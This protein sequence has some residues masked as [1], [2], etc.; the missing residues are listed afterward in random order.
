ASLGS[1]QETTQVLLQTN[2]QLKAEYQKLQADIGAL[3]NT[4][5]AVRAKNKEQR[6]AF[7]QRKADIESPS[8]IAAVKQQIA[9][10]DKE[11]ADRKNS[12]APGQARLASADAKLSLRRLQVAQL[13]L[14]KKALLVDLRV[15]DEALFV[16]MQ[17]E[18]S[19]L[20]AQIRA[21]REQ[22]DFLKTKL[23]ELQNVD[24]P[25]VRDARHIADVNKKLKENLLLLAH[26]RDA[27]EDALAEI[28][29]QRAVREA[30][31]N[32]RRYDELTRSKPELEAK[33]KALKAEKEALDKAAAEVIAPNADA[34]A[35][36]ANYAK[37]NKF[38]EQQSADLRENIAVLDY[39]VS[40][41]ERYK[42]RNQDQKKH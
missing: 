31:L 20:A 9:A 33:L 16:K 27:A 19:R 10:K 5:A 28:K 41:L 7:T 40:T 1:I 12:L 39:K 42:N 8:D 22:E 21:Q 4:I 17:N 32:V 35:D 25:Y 36:I 2:D 11:L 26:D 18:I 14:Q 15:R 34:E 23:H 37:Q 3:E 6:A 24:L 30:D 29:K 13:E 38:I